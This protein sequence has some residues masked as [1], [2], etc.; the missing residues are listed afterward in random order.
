MNEADYKVPTLKAWFIFFIVATLLGALCGALAGG[1]AGAAVVVLGLQIDP[2][3]AG[4]IAGYVVAIP[5]SFIV[6]SWTINK[7]IVPR[8]IDD[9]Y[10][11]AE[12]DQ[13]QPEHSF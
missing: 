8:V 1:I 2:G 12:N 6:Y 4:A 9:I 11:L 7:Y 3:T 10:A 13:P 5:V